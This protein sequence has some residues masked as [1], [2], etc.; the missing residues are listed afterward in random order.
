MPT[1][2]R[3]LLA[4]MLPLAGLPILAAAASNESG[5]H[6]F[7]G[8]QVD[9]VALL[10]PPPSE[11][12][13]AQQADLRAVLEAQR[14]AHAD[15][16]TAHA[17]ADAQA[18]C[19]RFSDALGYDLTAP[20]GVKV[21][22]F[23]DQTARQGALISVPAKRYWR[24]TRPYAYSTQVE[25]LGDIAPQSTSNQ[26]LNMGGTSDVAAQQ[27]A[28]TLA[29]SSYPSGHATFGTECAILLAEVV[30]EKRAALF[31]RNLDYDHSRMVVGAHFPSD[32]EAGRIAGTIAAALMLENPRVQ[33]EL[34]EAGASLRAALGLPAAPPLAA[35]PAPAAAPPVPASPALP[36]ASSSRAM[37]GSK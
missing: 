10:P 25:R 12:S 13:P 31:A 9:I 27:A 22:A 35:A 19:G 16:S 7:F 32:L 6:E 24:R 11:D 29:H 8:S 30:P 15:G 14:A 4:V 1:G 20:G 18:S 23:L 28:D 34:T 36:A 17:V 3:W 33:R 37:P 5:P 21:L 26:E 2:H